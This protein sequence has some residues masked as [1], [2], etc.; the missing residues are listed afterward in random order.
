M[1]EIDLGLWDS[2]AGVPSINESRYQCTRPP[3]EYEESWLTTRR[4]CQGLVTYLSICL[5]NILEPVTAFTMVLLLLMEP[6]IQDV[7]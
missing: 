5:T 3:V 7:P 1:E 4:W 2:K 6:R